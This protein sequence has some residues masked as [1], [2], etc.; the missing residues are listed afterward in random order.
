[1][2]LQIQLSPEAESRLEQEAARRGLDTGEYARVLI[3]QNLAASASGV[4]PLW[5]SLSPEEWVRE[6]EAW[7]ES[8]RDLPVLPPEAYERASSYEGRD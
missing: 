4:Q 2:T 1:M 5:K 7:T 3:E 6:F 8:H